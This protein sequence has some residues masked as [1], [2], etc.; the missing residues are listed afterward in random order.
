VTTIL[1]GISENS[2]SAIFPGMVQTLEC[3][4]SEGEYVL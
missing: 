2:F 4:K 3:V 1:K